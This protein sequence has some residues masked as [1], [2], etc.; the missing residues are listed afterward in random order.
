MVVGFGNSAVDIACEAARFSTGKVWISTRSGAHVLP[1]YILGM[2]FDTLNKYSVEWLPMAAQR[3]LLAFFLWIARGKQSRYGIPVPKKPLLS[4]H[5]TISQE[6]FSLAGHG[7]I[8][9]KPNI[10]ELQGEHILFED[11]SRE[12]VDILIYATGYKIALPFFDKDFLYVEE[13]NRLQLYKHVVH[14]E[15]LGLYFIGFVQPLGAIMP[16]AETQAIWV[17]HLLKGQSK[18]P[19]KASMYRDIS[20]YEKR[21]RKRY[22]QSPRHTIQVDFYPYKRTI[23]RLYKRPPRQGIPVGIF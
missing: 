4:E 18:L 23:E 10:S 5:P 22:Q 17:A 20:Q 6:L 8:G 2:P 7:R 13:D 19:D 1:K 9:F 12:R 21:L 15:H 16:L 14:P 3:A 11:G